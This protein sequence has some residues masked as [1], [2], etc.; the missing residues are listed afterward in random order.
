MVCKLYLTKLGQLA[1]SPNLLDEVHLK[2]KWI[3]VLQMKTSI[4]DYTAKKLKVQIILTHNN[5]YE[6]KKEENPF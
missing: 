3:V 2:Y 1:S 6:H 4:S 5:G